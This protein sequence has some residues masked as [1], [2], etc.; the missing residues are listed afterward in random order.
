MTLNGEDPVH[1]AIPPGRTVGR[2]AAGTAVTAADL[3]RPLPRRQG[4]RGARRGTHPA[5]RAAAG[6][7]RELT[8][9]PSILESPVE[10][11]SIVVDWHALRTVVLGCTKQF[12]AEFSD[13]I[14]P[15]VEVV[16]LIPRRH[17]RRLNSPARITSYKPDA[18]AT[19]A[20]SRQYSKNDAVPRD[21]RRRNSNV[22]MAGIMARGLKSN[23]SP[24]SALS[25]KSSHDI[26]LFLCLLAESRNRTIA[27]SCPTASEIS[28][29]S[30]QLASPNVIFPPPVPS[31]CTPKKR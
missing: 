20:G 1:A 29:L 10:R 21:R 31:H 23:G 26:D 19:L 11:P 18:V 27:D 4:T 5:C 9:L 22:V 7:N 15:N 16:E 25:G 2:T 13:Y 30:K 28:S 6:L 24:I 17:A 8:V 14:A 3:H 12:L